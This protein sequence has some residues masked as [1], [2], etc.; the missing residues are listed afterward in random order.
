M[1]QELL[2]VLAI[3]KSKHL[4]TMFYK[5]IVQKRGQYLYGIFGNGQMQTQESVQQHQIYQSP[6]KQNNI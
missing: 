2:Y 3:L 4:C 1:C 6:S 5:E